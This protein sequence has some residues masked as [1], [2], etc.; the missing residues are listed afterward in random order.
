MLCLAP[1]RRL[2]D[3]AGGPSTASTSASSPAAIGRG[4]TTAHPSR[5]GRLAALYSRRRAG[6]A[7]F[8]DR[9]PVVR[10][11]YDGIAGDRA[12]KRPRGRRR[13]GFRPARAQPA[14]QGMPHRH[15]QTCRAPR[16]RRLLHC[17]SAPTQPAERPDVSQPAIWPDEC[18]SCTGPKF[19]L[20]PCRPA[21]PSSCGSRA[22]GGRSPSKRSNTCGTAR[23][24]REPRRRRPLSGCFLG[25]SRELS[26]PLSSTSSGC[27]WESSSVSSD[28]RR[29]RDARPA[30]PLRGP[31][32]SR[33]KGR[34]SLGQPW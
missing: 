6:F 34:C 21:K 16:A 25:S 17:R 27:R 32:L 18:S 33:Q 22:S 19:G 11:Q 9:D 13:A 8:R 5:N 3:A 7:R 20:I 31:R 23:V 24:P 15:L 29:R 12:E 28:T 4:V 14:R 10:R 26:T 2:G 30:I 1:F